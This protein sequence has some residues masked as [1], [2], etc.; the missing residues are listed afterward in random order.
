MLS[1]IFSGYSYDVLSL[2]CIYMSIWIFIIEIIRFAF[3][4]ICWQNEHLYCSMEMLT[5]I[6]YKRKEEMTRL[7]WL[8]PFLS[9]AE[10]MPLTIPLYLTLFCAIWASVCQLCPALDISSSTD[11]RQVFL[12]LSGLLFPLGFYIKTWRVM[13]LGSCLSVCPIKV[14]FLSSLARLEEFDWFAARAPGCW[15]SFRLSDSE[16]SA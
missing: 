10:H 2:M 7:T 8:T 12:G 15:C 9:C 14:H 5:L 4:V 11:I 13:L 1:S 6:Q 16:N 3:E